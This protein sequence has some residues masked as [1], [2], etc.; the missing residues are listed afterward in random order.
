M[1]FYLSPL[2]DLIVIIAVQRCMIPIIDVTRSQNLRVVLNDYLCRI[3]DR[4]DTLITIVVIGYW[5][6]GGLSGYLNRIIVD[7]E[8]VGE[9]VFQG[10]RL[11]VVEHNLVGIDGNGELC[12]IP[13]AR[14]CFVNDG[15]SVLKLNRG[16]TV[17][18]A[19]S[20]LELCCTTIRQSLLSGLCGILHNEVVRNPVILIQIVVII[21]RQRRRCNYPVATI[22]LPQCCL[23]RHASIVAR[24]WAITV[25]DFTIVTMR[26]AI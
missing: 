4:K 5:P 14:R 9:D 18:P 23:L 13:I 3:W 22:S 6:V 20:V 7:R 12:L 16:F 26:L 19:G 11:V 10:H 8:R 1:G 25:P 21:A 2:V 15:M 17:T 24:V